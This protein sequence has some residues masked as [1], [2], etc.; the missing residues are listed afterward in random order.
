MPKASELKKGMVVEIQGVPHIVKHLESK[1]PSSR[2][3]VTLYKIEFRNLQNGS[4]VD[5]SLKGG[6]LLPLA[7]FIRIPVQ[8]SYSDSDNLYFMNSDTFEQFEIARDQLSEQLPFLSEQQEDIFALVSGERILAIELPQSVDLRVEET[9]PAISGS[10]ATNR[11]K[12]AKLST[13]LEIQ[14][15]EYLKPGDFVRVNTATGKFMS[16][17]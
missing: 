7:D 1:S 8:Y 6:D 14:V 16:R 10:S 15:P 9:P 17:V 5:S 11:T 3:A 4:K 2:G 13:G 12:T